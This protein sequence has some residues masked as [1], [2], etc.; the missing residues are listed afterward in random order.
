[1]TD[2]R[3]KTVHVFPPI[4]A[5]TFDWMAY[6]EDQEGDENALIGWG[7]TVEMAI[8]DLKWVAEDEEQP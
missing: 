5:R 6:F 8:E 2:R 1:M 4:P 3:I 7:P